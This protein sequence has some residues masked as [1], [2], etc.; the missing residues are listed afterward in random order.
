MYPFRLEKNMTYF[1]LFNIPVQLSVDTKLL[2][3]T[4]FALS[5]KYHPDYFANAT[6]EEKEEALEKSSLLN[7][8]WKTFQK[9]DELIKY[10]L[11]LKGVLVED[12]K[13]SLDPD[14]LMEVMDLNEALMDG[15]ETN[16][17]Y[18]AKIAHLQEEIYRPVA[19]I[20][21]NYQDGITPESDLLKVKEYY[22]QKKYLDRLQNGLK[23]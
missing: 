3:S 17:N 18:P 22:Y 12:E 1:S 11:Q 5:R 9:K 19:G 15:S 7:K 6:E 21:E 14:F 16:S 2:S 4:F 10:V 8:A 13:Y 23:D 20:I